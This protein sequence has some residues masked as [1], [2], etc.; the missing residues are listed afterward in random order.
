[1]L[2]THEK[3]R[4]AAS[5]GISCKQWVGIDL[6]LHRSVIC[7]IDERGHELK[8]VRIDND[9][10]ALIA[11]VR[12]A[13]RG[14]P[15]AIE[16]TYGWYWSVDALTAAKCEVHLAH[17]YGLKAMRKRKRVKTDRV[18][19][20]EL[21]NLLRLGSLPEA[22]I[23]PPELSELRELVRHRRQLVKTA[24]ATKNGIRGL[25]AKH[26]LRL[27]VSNL[28]GIAGARA[29]DLVELPGSYA[30]RLHSQRRLLMLLSNEI[31]LVDAE[32]D[33]RLKHHPGYQNLLKV[34][35][36]G[37]VLAAVFV[38]EIGDISRF[39]GPQ[40][41]TCW[42][43]LT[44]RHYE[45]DKT[46]RRTDISKVGCTLVRWAAVEAIQRQCEPHVREVRDRILARRGN[47]ARN[48]AKIAAARTMLEVVYY[49]LRDGH[50]RCLTSAA[51]APTA[52]A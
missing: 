14:A 19:A 51:P 16:A 46:V 22:Y 29:L 40:Q 4:P 31:D 35:G 27:S 20:H 49:V 8:W 3:R 52:A 23:A 47:T 50:A 17:P 15:V 7:R 25:L 45:S 12:K 28:D 26:G 33:R 24:T 36:I 13:G 34:K 5:D 6:H 43:G 39:P 42:A 37:P 10:K 9:P 32:L 1:V 38:V 30:Q 11:E 44:P 48:T 18:D 41:L 2:T 21:A